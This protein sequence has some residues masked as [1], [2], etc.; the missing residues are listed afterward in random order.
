MMAGL[1]ASFEGTQIFIW[2][3]VGFVPKSVTRTR[4]PLTATVSKASLE[5]KDVERNMMMKA[6][7]GEFGDTRQQK[8]SPE[9]LWCIYIFTVHEYQVCIQK[10]QSSTLN[11]TKHFIYEGYT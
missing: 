7:V 6:T 3:L 9:I 5:I 1:A 11:Q 8:V 2:R 10:E 4:A